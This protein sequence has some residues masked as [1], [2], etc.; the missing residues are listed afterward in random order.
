MQALVRDQLRYEQAMGED[1]A[2]D[3]L[4]KIPCR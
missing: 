4:I 2:D 1:M 3:N